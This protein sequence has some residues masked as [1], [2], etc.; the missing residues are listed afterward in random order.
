VARHRNF[1]RALGIVF[2]VWKLAELPLIACAVL[3][4]Q[5]AWIA[6]Q[7]DRLNAASRNI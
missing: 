5:S 7:W 2:V 4:E 3:F 6:R 1:A